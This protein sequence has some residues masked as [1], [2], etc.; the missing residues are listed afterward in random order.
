[1]TTH[2]KSGTLEYGI[3]C[4]MIQRCHNENRDRY[5]WYGKR[6]IRVCD[7]WRESFEAFIEDMGPRPSLKHS[8]ERIDNEKG[9]EPDN[10]VWA[11]KVVQRRNRRG[12]KRFL[13]NG[14]MLMLSEIAEQCG[15][16]LYTLQNRV[17][18]LGWTVER[19]V[20]QPKRK[21]PSRL[22]REPITTD[23]LN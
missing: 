8:I 10:C 23:K 16:N 5:K 15:I 13:Y 12:V 4:S 2:G 14:K 18:V 7:R 11:T 3:W 6:G 22:D 19:A 1:M 21:L 17:N 9:Y 20:S